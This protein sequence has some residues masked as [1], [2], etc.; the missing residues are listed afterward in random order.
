MTQHAWTYPD[1]RLKMYDHDEKNIRKIDDHHYP[2]YHAVLTLTNYLRIKAVQWD[3][4]SVYFKNKKL[5]YSQFQ[6]IFSHDPLCREHYAK[7]SYAFN[8]LM[9]PMC[10]KL[11]F[12]EFKLIKNSDTD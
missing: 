12:S 11:Y 7:R 10:F 6:Y 1:S 2:I 9:N 4:F 5:K 3:E 8:S